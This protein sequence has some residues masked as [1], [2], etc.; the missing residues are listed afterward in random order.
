MEQWLRPHGMNVFLN[1]VCQYQRRF[2]E[3]Q[4]DY[5]L[6]V[7]IVMKFLSYLDNFQYL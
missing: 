6:Q 7:A 3:I 5:D 2:Q 4:N 1:N